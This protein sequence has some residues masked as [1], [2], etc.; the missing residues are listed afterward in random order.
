MSPSNTTGT[1]TSVA[2]PSPSTTSVTP[3]GPTQP[4]IADNCNKYAL[5]E[6]GQDCD[7]FA[8]ANDITT[9][10]LC[11]K[12]T[13]GRLIMFQADKKTTDAWNTVLNGT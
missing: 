11:K 1:Q 6:T 12:K 10:N 9:A 2:P 4:G 7:D 8:A 13:P 3:P 5:A